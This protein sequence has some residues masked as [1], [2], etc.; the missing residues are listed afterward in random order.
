M[1]WEYEGLYSELD[2]LEVDLGL[3]AP[4]VGVRETEIPLTDEQGGVFEDFARID[5]GHVSWTMQSIP[6]IAELQIE[7]SK[8]DGPY[9][10]LEN[11]EEVLIDGDDL[12]LEHGDTLK[13]RQTMTVENIRLYPDGIFTLNEFILTLVSSR[14][15][16][17]IKDV[18]DSQWETEVYEEVPW[19]IPCSPDD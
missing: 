11:D 19:G 2:A 9:S 13:L 5:F 3:V 10:L 17:D 8:N 1:D 14:L 6:P 18:G 16:W 15:G 12:E 7:M 4:F